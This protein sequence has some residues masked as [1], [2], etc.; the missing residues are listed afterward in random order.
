ML[1]ILNS[2]HITNKFRSFYCQNCSPSSSCRTEIMAWDPE[3]ERG[4]FLFPYLHLLTHLCRRVTIPLN[5]VQVEATDIDI[6]N[7]VIQ[8]GTVE[9]E[10]EQIKINYSVTFLF[11]DGGS[12]LS[13]TITHFHAKTGGENI[14][15][16]NAKEILRFTEKS[17]I[18][19]KKTCTVKKTDYLCTPF[20]R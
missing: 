4:T 3:Q 14:S 5:F 7:P 11:I 20:H 15:L 18:S 17:I 1:H 19:R 9:N 13:I 12:T 10:C 6:A 2:S 8:I 16:I